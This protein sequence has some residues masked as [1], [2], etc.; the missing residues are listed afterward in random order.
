MDARRDERWPWAVVIVVLLGTGASNNEDDPRWHVTVAVVL[1]VAAALPAVTRLS[2]PVALPVA[3]L[4]TGA[5]FAAGF[6]DGPIFLALPTV[7]FVVASRHPPRSWVGWV[8][9]GLGLSLAGLVVRTSLGD[10]DR[11]EDVWQFVGLLGLTAAAGALATA[12]HSRQDASRDRAQRAATEERLR[13][14]QDLH[15]GVGHGLAVIAM[16]AGVGLHVLDRDP[17]KARASLEAIRATS[18]EALGAL[19]AELSRMSGEPAARRPAPGLA[20]VPA[21]VDR[22][23]AAGLRV[24]VVGSPGIVGEEAG[25]VAYAVVQ[26]A[27]TNVLRHARAERTV[28]SFDRIGARAVVAVTDHGTGPGRDVGGSG[29]GVGMGIGGMRAKVEALDGTFEAAPTADGFR[30]RAELPA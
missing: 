25:R 24:E 6:A 5:Y 4:A 13:M 29:M 1:A 18:T 10:G 15:D 8:C 19:R 12:V 23:R 20:E 11:G 17:A 26:E 28:V 16:Q 22:V 21:L 9:G 30:V 7:A 14:A 2:A 27:L 3:G